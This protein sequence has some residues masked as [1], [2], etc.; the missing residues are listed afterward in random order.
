[1]QKIHA[2]MSYPITYLKLKDSGQ[3]NLFLFRMVTIIKKCLAVQER[4][5]SQTTQKQGKRK[6]GTKQRNHIKL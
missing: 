1:M 2:A 5:A 4:M 6:G 3:M